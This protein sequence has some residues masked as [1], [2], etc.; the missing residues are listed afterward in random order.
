M[1]LSAGVS[2]SATPPSSLIWKWNGSDTSQFGSDLLTPVGG[3]VTLDVD[4]ANSERN[5]LRLN[6]S[7]W[8]GRCLFP[9]T[10]PNLPDRFVLRFELVNQTGG[11]TSSD[12]LAIAF[13][14]NLASGSS[15]RALWLQKYV[16]GS[17]LILGQVEGDAV[18]VST[19]TLTGGSNSVAA[20]TARYGCVEELEIL[21][22]PTLGATPWF[23][24]R[25]MKSVGDNN[26]GQDAVYSGNLAG[27]WSGWASLAKNGIGLGAKYNNTI[28]GVL[29]VG[30]L[31]VWT[32][33]L[34]A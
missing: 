17:N 3:T 30:E 8:S 16:V 11:T 32:H 28:T 12:N 6:F 4:S 21:T 7:G 15:L 1:G 2:A 25:A 14:S 20:G 31:S 10:I 24:A 34:D 9:V 19:H 23:C 27:P 5:Y 33:P 22:E 18:P 29:T 26:A 13:L